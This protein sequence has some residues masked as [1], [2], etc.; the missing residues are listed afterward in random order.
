[1]DADIV[2]IGT[3]LF[4]SMA[5]ISCFCL[6]VTG[7]ELDFIFLHGK[8]SQDIFFPKVPKSY[9]S[10]MYICGALCGLMVY[11]YV[12][13]QLDLQL[14]AM[15]QLL[16][17][18]RYLECIYLTI[19]GDSKMTI[20]VYAG[21]L[22]HYFVAPWT[23]L[24]SADIHFA[25][26]SKLLWVRLISIAIYAMASLLQCRQHEV[27][28]RLKRRNPR[29]PYTFPCDSLFAYVCCPH[30]TCEIFIYLSFWVLSGGR[31]SVSLLCLWVIT[32]LAM[33]ADR[34]YRWYYVHFKGVVPSHWKRLI[35]YVW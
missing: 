27:L 11:Y 8:L 35:P 20:I 32:N 9:F 31:T 15:L 6:I 34:N 12:G 30:Y 21:G 26:W 25:T 33:M 16:M 19:Y 23:L 24:V 1:M 3:C 18:R 22:A 17:L 4:W 28:Y 2:N 29:G 5:T 7:T 10:H 13:F 14:F